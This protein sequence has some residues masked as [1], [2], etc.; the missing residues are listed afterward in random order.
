MPFQFPRPLAPSRRAQWAGIWDDGAPVLD[1]YEHYPVPDP[2]TVVG[3]NVGIVLDKALAYGKKTGT[4]PRALPII[5]DAGGSRPAFAVGYSPCVTASRAKS[6]WFFSLQHGRPLTLSELARLQGIPASGIKLQGVT[7]P[8][9][10]HAIGNSFT[11][12]VVRSI[13]V[14]AIAAAQSLPE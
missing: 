12:P 1:T 4:D 7:P 3:R 5:I 9:F 6:R 10:G 8:T 11:V 14:N 13:L 2:A